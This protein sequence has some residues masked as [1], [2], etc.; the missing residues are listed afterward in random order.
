[1]SP[2]TSPGRCPAAPAHRA[3]R[4]PRCPATRSG[5]CPSSAGY[6]GRE[7][8]TQSSNP[9]SRSGSRRRRSLAGCCQASS[10]EAR[11]RFALRRTANCRCSSVRPRT[12]AAQRARSS[13]E[14]VSGR[15]Q[16]LPKPQTQRARSWA[17]SRSEAQPDSHSPATERPTHC[18]ANAWSP[19][20]DVR[21]YR[22]DTVGQTADAIYVKRRRHPRRHRQAQVAVL[23]AQPCD[24]VRRS[25]PRKVLT[26]W[27]NGY[28]AAASATQ[29]GRNG[30]GVKCKRSATPRNCS[31][32]SPEP[33]SWRA[34][35]PSR[36]VARP[37]GTDKSASRTKD[38]APRTKDTA[39]RPSQWST[40][41]P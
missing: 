14:R 11:R 41:R 6:P 16:E 25:S 40:E 24:R 23:R 10:N 27:L 8:R 13:V 39:P 31:P 32:A 37:P 38:T 3:A 1:M 18:S 35:S 7:S 2:A 17:Q 19:P 30:Q 4:T 29:P 21:G 9:R 22:H 26:Q 5:S 34:N 36:R 15:R 28:F 12:L 33:P 20:V